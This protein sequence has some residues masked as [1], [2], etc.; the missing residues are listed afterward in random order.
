MQMLFCIMKL[1]ITFHCCVGTFFLNSFQFLCLCNFILHL[2]LFL[3]LKLYYFICMRMIVFRTSQMPTPP[4]STYMNFQTTGE[5]I[6]NATCWLT[7]IV[8]LWIHSCN[9]MECQDFTIIIYEFAS[10]GCVL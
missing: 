3:L 5:R 4:N 9:C 8:L 6:L 10:F 7:V 1:M 2:F